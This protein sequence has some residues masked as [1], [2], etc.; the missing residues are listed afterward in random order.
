M[1]CQVKILINLKGGSNVGIFIF[2]ILFIV[3]LMAIEVG[4]GFNDTIKRQGADDHWIPGAVGIIVLL[5]LL[6]AVCL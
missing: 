6:A 3:G 4:I 1:I 2:L 5:I